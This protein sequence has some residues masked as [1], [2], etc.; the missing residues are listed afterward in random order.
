MRSRTDGGAD[1][2]KLRI[3]VTGI[4]LAIGKEALRINPALPVTTAMKPPTRV[5]GIVT[6]TTFV[7]DTV[8]A[9]VAHQ[10]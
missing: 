4:A 3:V 10:A 2:E 1:V 9:H 7:A 6:G 8:L 5:V